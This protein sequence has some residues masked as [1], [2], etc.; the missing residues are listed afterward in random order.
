[1]GL[2]SMVRWNWKL[3]Q[4]TLKMGLV[5]MGIKK[6]SVYTMKYTAVFLMLWAYVSAGGPGHLVLTHGIMD[7]QIK[8]I[9]KWPT[10][11]EIL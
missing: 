11:L 9:S 2:A 6:Y 7:Q 10:L 1:M 8:K 3:K 5:N 4:Q